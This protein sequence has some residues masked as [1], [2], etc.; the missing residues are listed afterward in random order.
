[1]VAAI[2]GVSVFQAS[3][4]NSPEMPARLADTSAGR[5]PPDEPIET[6]IDQAEHI[7]KQIERTSHEIR[8]RTHDRTSAR[9]DNLNDLAIAQSGEAARAD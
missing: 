6:K 9:F 2:L 4:F 5:P 7:L 3:A 1:V 8:K